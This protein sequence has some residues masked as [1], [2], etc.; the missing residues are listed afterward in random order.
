MSRRPALAVSFA[1]TLLVAFAV[2]SLASQAHWL[3]AK[4][5][6]ADDAVAMQAPEDTSSQDEAVS[7][8][9]VIITEYQYEDIFVERPKPAPPAAPTASPTPQPAPPQ[10]Q[11]SVSQ[12]SGPSASPTAVATKREE[13]RV[14]PTQPPSSPSPAAR[15]GGEREP[16][17]EDEHEHEHEDEPEHEDDD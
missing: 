4:S 16:D 10:T 8:E 14:A 13:P 15:R 3:E 6:Q 17:D 2:A 5:D 7:Q 12:S 1:L 9:P 11:A